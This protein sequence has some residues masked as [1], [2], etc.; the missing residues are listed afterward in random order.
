MEALGAPTVDSRVTEKQ[1]A[2]VNQE[3]LSWLGSR[4]S[5][6]RAP[7]SHWSTQDKT[8]VPLHGLNLNLFIYL[9]GKSLYLELRTGVW[10][11]YS[12]TTC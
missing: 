10:D 6:T 2:T 9:V 3:M 8:Q 5:N 1:G 12:S 7:G 11:L 4:M